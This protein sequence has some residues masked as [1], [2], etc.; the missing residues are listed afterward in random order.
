MSAELAVMSG[1]DWKRRGEGVEEGMKGMLL[2]ASL[3]G[4]SSFGDKHRVLSAK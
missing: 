3:S 4:A 1:Q 2:T